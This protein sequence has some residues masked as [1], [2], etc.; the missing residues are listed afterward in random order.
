MQQGVAGALRGVRVLDLSRLL[1]GPMCTQLLAD[2]GASV[3]RVEDPRQ[4]DAARLVPPHLA[5]GQGACFHAVN[6]GKHVM[7]LD[8]KSSEGREQL[9]RMCAD[10]DVLVE[11]HRPGVMAR[12]QLS[13]TT[14]LQAHPHLVVCSIS[15]YGATTDLAARAGHDL[16][17]MA[18]SGVLGMMKQP[19]VL[20]V[21][22]ADV[23]GGA[24]SA[25]LQI[26]AAL[27]AKQQ[28]GHGCHIDVNM[29]AGA[30]AAAAMSFARILAG[31]DVG[32]DPLLGEFACYHV[33][34]CADGHVAVGALEPKFWWAMCDALELHELRDRG[35]DRGDDGADVKAVLTRTFL[36][37]G[38][39][40]WQQI[41]AHIDACVDVVATPQE[42]LA[43][44]AFPMVA[45]AI[46]GTRER[47]PHTALHASHA[48]GATKPPSV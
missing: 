39:A 38:R 34:P 16:N 44:A 32:E 37:H 19:Q 4:G 23:A 24:M 26:C 22:M 47:I 9:L 28:H 12:L 17:Y 41:F 20:P 5:D 3:T 48:A 8:L 6:R 31:S 13:A 30:Q 45:V 27:L 25:A 2:M 7:Q 42:A 21:Q 10:A 35:Y 15:G 11:S 29:M 18:R 46:E 40:H 43:Q 33:Y 14:L 1:P 36:A